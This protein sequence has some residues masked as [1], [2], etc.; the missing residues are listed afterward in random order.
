LTNKSFEKT[1]IIFRL[2]APPNGSLS[3]VAGEIILESEQITESVFYVDFPE[4]Q[5]HGTSI[6]IIIEIVSGEVIIDEITTSFMGPER[7]G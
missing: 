4:N 6:M 7:K 3:M 1:P 5:L 2:K